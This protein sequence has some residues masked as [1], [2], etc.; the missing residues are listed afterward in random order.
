MKTA[1]VALFVAAIVL[2]GASPMV[3]A[4]VALAVLFVLLGK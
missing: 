4:A 1:A 3:A 2:S